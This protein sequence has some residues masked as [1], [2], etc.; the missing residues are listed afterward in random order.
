MHN[1]PVVV[2]GEVADR[3]AG[4][5]AHG[6]HVVGGGEAHVHRVPAELHSVHDERFGRLSGLRKLNERL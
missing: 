6:I 4:V 5:S 1:L 2:L 3:G